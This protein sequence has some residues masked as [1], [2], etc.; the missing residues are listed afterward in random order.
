[1]SFEQPREEELEEIESSQE[2]EMS[3]EQLAEIGERV[4][5][6]IAMTKEE[7]EK[8]KGKKKQIIENTPEGEDPNLNKDFQYIENVLPAFVARLESLEGLAGQDVA[9]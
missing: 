2:K 8:L 6:G 1:M 3:Q 7:I 9:E 5:A 4:L